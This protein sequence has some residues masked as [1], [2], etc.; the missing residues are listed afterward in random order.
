M[1]A[2]PKMK[3]KMPAR[4]LCLSFTLL[5]GHWICLVASRCSFISCPTAE[6]Q[7]ALYSRNR[8]VTQHSYGKE[9]SR[10]VTGRESHGSYASYHASKTPLFLAN[11][12]STP[13]D[14][15]YGPTW[16]DLSGPEPGCVLVCA[17]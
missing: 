3:K 16:V 13:S 6:Q 2:S 11:K 5:L 15:E 14:Q 4:M 1:T 17:I 8:R 10:L 7:T 9:K 12:L